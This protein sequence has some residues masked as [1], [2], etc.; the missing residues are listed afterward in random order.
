MV[1][2]YVDTDDNIGVH[3]TFFSFHFSRHFVL[4]SRRKRRF[5]FQVSSFKSKVK[6]LFFTLH[7]SLFTCY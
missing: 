4:V 2:D 6:D 1:R 3:N 7:L 5:K